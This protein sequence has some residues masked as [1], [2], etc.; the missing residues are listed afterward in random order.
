MD[1]LSARYLTEAE[2]RAMIFHA[3]AL[4]IRRLKH[5]VYQAPG[6]TLAIYAAGLRALNDFYHLYDDAPKK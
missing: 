1:E 6:L 3:G 4:H 5:Q 2:R